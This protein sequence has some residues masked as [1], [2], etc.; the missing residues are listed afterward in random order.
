MEGS[1]AHSLGLATAPLCGWTERGWD[2]LRAAAL[3]SGTDPG[4]AIPRFVSGLSPP[5]RLAWPRQKQS[6]KQQFQ[7]Q[8]GHH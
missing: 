6:R 4:R 5:G 7:W 1:A 8:Q 2:G 3:V